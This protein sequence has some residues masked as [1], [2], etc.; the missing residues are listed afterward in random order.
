MALHPF[1]GEGLWAG[2]TDVIVI[3]VIAVEAMA[4][5]G[6]IVVRDDAPIV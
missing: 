6:A 2:I 5:G 1:A 4:R 3:V